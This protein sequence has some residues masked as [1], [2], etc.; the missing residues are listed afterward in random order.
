[1]TGFRVDDGLPRASESGR[2]PHGPSESRPGPN[3]DPRFRRAP[4]KLRPDK[5]RP[6]SE[7]ATVGRLA[8]DSESDDLA[9]AAVGRGVAPAARESESN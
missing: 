6:Q 8:R 5:L 3:R 2:R 9:A 1:M 4:I 7:S